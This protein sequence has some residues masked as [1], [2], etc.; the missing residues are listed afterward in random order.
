MAYL[1]EKLEFDSSNMPP[2]PMVVDILAKV[3]HAGQ[4]GR[5]EFGGRCPP[6]LCPVRRRLDC[7]GGGR[8]G[9]LAPAVG[10]VAWE[11]GTVDD[12]LSTGKTVERFD[13]T[14]RV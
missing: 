2:P 5:V 8:G 10:G 7:S 3:M 4:Q 1:I 11:G 13:F 9:P 6:S 14:K 12:G